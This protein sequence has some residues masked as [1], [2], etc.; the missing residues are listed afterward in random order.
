MRQNYFRQIPEAYADLV[1]HFYAEARNGAREKIFQGHSPFIAHDPE[2]L[3]AL[4]PVNLGIDSPQ[5]RHAVLMNQ[6]HE[7]GRFGN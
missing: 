7:I 5:W 4:D 1:G 2:R 3:L 6:F